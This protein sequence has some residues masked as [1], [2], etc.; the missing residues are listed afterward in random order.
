MPIRITFDNP[1][2]FNDLFSKPKD[3]KKDLAVAFDFTE[4]SILPPP[5]LDS[6]SPFTAELSAS[7]TLNSLRNEDKVFKPAEAS[8]V[9]SSRKYF[10]R[11][12]ENISSGTLLF[13]KEPSF[14]RPP[15][16]PLDVE[17]CFKP[18]AGT[19]ISKITRKPPKTGKHGH[20]KR[21][22]TREAKDSKPKPEKVKSQSKKVKPWSNSQS[23]H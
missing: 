6:D 18:E 2:D 14:P 12:P 4:S 20:E 9:T 5:L 23:L 13:L 8:N 17:K 10:T 19:D 11:S 16:E 22:S 15:P 3:L 7:V 1:I 21:K